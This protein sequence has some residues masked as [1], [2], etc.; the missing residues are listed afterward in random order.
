MTLGGDGNPVYGNH[1]TG[2]LTTTSAARFNQWYN[3]I[4]N[5]NLCKDFSITLNQVGD[6][7]TYKFSDLSFF[8][9]DNQLFGNQGFSHN[10]HFTMEL[11]A[12]FV[13]HENTDQQFIVNGD[14]DIFL[15]VDGD[16]VYDGGGVLPARM[17]TV[18]LDTLGLMDGETYDFDMFFAERHTTQSVLEITVENLILIPKAAPC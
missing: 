11:R 9:I 17:T 18:D 2:T 6:T 12:T 3:T 16:L 15:Y 5:V 10:Y 8:P 1:P 14:D 7:N 4:N 13:Y